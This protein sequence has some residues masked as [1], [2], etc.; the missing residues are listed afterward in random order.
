MA[1]GFFG[2]GHLVFCPQARGLGSTVS[3]PSE[4]L[5]GSPAAKLF[6]CILK[7]PVSLFYYI[8]MVKSPK[9]GSKGIAPTPLEGQKLH[10]QGG[11]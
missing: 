4:V 7:F 2:M 1:V 9:S 3:S 6:P 11:Y 5:G 8:I 10:E